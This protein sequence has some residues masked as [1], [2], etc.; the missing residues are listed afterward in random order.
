MLANYDEA[1][2]HSRLAREREREDMIELDGAGWPLCAA[3]ASQYAESPV[4]MARTGATMVC[5]L[6][7]AGI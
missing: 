7:S 4:S 3:F 5:G 6:A 1:M 2:I